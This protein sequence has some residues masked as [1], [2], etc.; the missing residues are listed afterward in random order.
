ME[1]LLSCFAERIKNIKSIIRLKGSRRSHESA[2]DL[3]PV[4]EINVA[5]VVQVAGNCVAVRFR[6]I[7]VI[8][9]RSGACKIAS[10]IDV[11]SQC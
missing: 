3:E 9:Q 1:V 8:R 5:G 10:S 11:S 4:L 2:L 6:P 7:S